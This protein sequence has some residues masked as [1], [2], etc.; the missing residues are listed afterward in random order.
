MKKLFLFATVAVAIAGCKSSNELDE[1]EE[2]INMLPKTRAIELTQEEKTY[3]EKNT[4]FS[5]NLFKTISNMPKGKK[6]SIISPISVTYVMGMLNDGATGETA[7][8]I[9]TVLGFG[10]NEVKA[11]NEFCQKLIEEAPKTDSSVTLEVANTVISNKFMNVKLESQYEKDMKNYYSAEVS[12]LDFS[13]KDEALKQ[14]NGWCKKKTDNMIPEILKENEL[15]IDA[16][17]LLMNA[18]YF[19][20]TWTDKFDKKDT[21]NEDFTA[22]DGQ[23]KSLPMMHRKA[24]ALYSENEM[25]QMLNLPYGSGDKWSMKVL[26]PKEGKTIDT[27]ISSM[28][29]LWWKELTNYQNAW[30]AEVDI[31]IPRFKTDF[32]TDLVEPL[33][34]MGA[35][36]MFKS[37]AEFPNISSN[38]KEGLHVGLM[39]QK[40]AIEVNEEGT[41]AA[42]VT[43]AMI[44]LMSPGPGHQPEKVDFH[45]NRPFIYVI[46]EASSGVIF[47]IG[48]YR[49]E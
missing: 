33:S 24:M 11:V 21:K 41:K 22:M 26:L 25:C 16:L 40:A 6:S 12:S 23:K 45:C 34:A 28:S 30:S 4:D 49:G 1:G 19:K 42:A 18:I 37:S 17:L 14:I 46:Q 39:K 29:S 20:A 47:F 5:F 44:D 32:E 35:P 31:M 7:K 15:N 43:V 8:E 38:I 3:V 13:K 27:V 36:T 9:G 48:T 2:V 10:Y